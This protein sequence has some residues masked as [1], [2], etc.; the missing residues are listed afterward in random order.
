M[1]N[2]KEKKIIDPKY[3]NFFITS[4][5]KKNVRKNYVFKMCFRTHRTKKIGLKI[6]FFFSSTMKNWGLE[7]SSFFN[8][9]KKKIEKKCMFKIVLRPIEPKK[10]V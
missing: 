10:L 6:N 9:S 7:L 1:G 8:V 3:Q 4:D 5:P 2:F